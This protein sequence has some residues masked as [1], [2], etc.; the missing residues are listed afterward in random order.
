M[1]SVNARQVSWP[2]EKRVCARR[3]VSA[4]RVPLWLPTFTTH[5]VTAPGNHQAS[6]ST[7]SYGA[8]FPF[9]SKV[10]CS[11]QCITRGGCAHHGGR[12]LEGK[13]W[14]RSGSVCALCTR[15]SRRHVA[16]ACELDPDP[17][18]APTVE[19]VWYV[20]Q[21]TERTEPTLERVGAHADGAKLMWPVCL[22]QVSG[23]GRVW[24]LLAAA[25]P[26]DRRRR[27]RNHLG[28]ACS[29][30]LPQL[31]PPKP[32]TACAFGVPLPDGTPGQVCLRPRP[33][34]GSC[35][36]C[37]GYPPP[38]AH[39]QSAC[40]LAA[41]HCLTVGVIGG[42]WFKVW[43]AG[44]SGGRTVARTTRGM[45]RASCAALWAFSSSPSAVSR[46]QRRG[47]SSAAKLHLWWRAVC[48]R[49]Q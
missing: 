36:P 9:N 5:V 29:W 23:V 44:A 35:C 42:G 45:R 6:S 12:G 19:G 14:V 20:M 7:A 18:P 16:P 49:R 37:C 40:A 47:F 32:L 4:R 27:W 15:P 48:A 3:E 8:V 10:K 30:P 21:Q 31:P 46:R 43:C 26:A 39:A 33:A 41:R 22:Q 2:D 17:G 24:R 28:P 25:V 34:P 38:C 11:N 1:I 13:R